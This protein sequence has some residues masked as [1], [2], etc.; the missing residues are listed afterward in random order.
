VLNSEWITPV[1]LRLVLGGEGLEGFDPTPYTDAYVAA[2]PPPGASYA[3]PF[4]PDDLRRRLPREEWPARRRC[5]VPR[6]DPERRRLTV[7]VVVHG[8]AGVGGP[9]AAAARPGDVLVFTGP[10]GAY[11]PDP[12]AD[13]HLLAGDESALPAIAAAAEA[14]PAARRSS[15]CWSVT[16]P[17]TRFRWTRLG[18]STADGE[19]HGG[20]GRL[21]LLGGHVRDVVERGEADHPSRDVGERADHTRAPPRAARARR[22]ERRD[23]QRRHHR[24]PWR[25]SYTTSRDLATSS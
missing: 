8:A 18:R 21:E 9:W 3:A 17:G 20:P 4:D 23:R 6:S 10:S 16:G 24:R 12:A 11:R 1:L 7:D 15:R 19:H 13:W 22:R 2:F 14:V 25:R 5:T